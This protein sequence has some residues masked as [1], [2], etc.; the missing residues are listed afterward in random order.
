M[1]E[2]MLSI[3]RFFIKL[4]HWEY[5]PFNVVYAP[6]LLV[7]LFL[8]LK[9][10]SF[11]FFS[12]SNP[13]I[14][15]GGFLLESKKD[16]YDLIPQ[17][18]Y[19][20]TLKFQPS[21]KI[22]TIVESASNYGIKFPF[23]AKPDKGQRGMQV[24]LIKNVTD[25]TL[26]LN[27]IKFEFLIQEFVDFKNEI[28]IFYYR[29]PTQQKGTISGIVGKE[30]LKL[31]GDG[32]STMEELIILEP[33]YLLQ[34]NILR[35]TYGSKL[36]H[37]LNKTEEVI[38][39]PYG[40]HSRGSK[41]ID[42][43]DQTDMVLQNMINQVCSEIP[44]FFFGRMDI[45]FNTWEELRQGKNFSIIELNGAGSEPAHIYDSNHSIFFAW[46]EI[47]RHLY[48]LYKISAINH[49][50]KSIPYLTPKTGL[51]MLRENQKQ[52]ELIS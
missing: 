44:E 13:L 36:N 42:L 30:F 33:R 21:S 39:V 48:L 50:L 40:N 7:Y 20:K 31:I 12:T 9:A 47:T 18:Y 46:K 1:Q 29:F 11:F 24:K 15:N 8:S 32:N 10:K 17:K 35:K 6:M 23:I 22:K 19:P 52:L 41:F 4:T 37:V 43:S 49:Q 45:K 5:W 34:L 51:E 3:R 16:I 28:G 2:V 38:L 14:K 27:E 26:Y 25:L